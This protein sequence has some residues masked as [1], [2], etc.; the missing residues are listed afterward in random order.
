[1]GGNLPWAFLMAENSENTE[2]GDQNTPGESKTGGD[3]DCEDIYVCLPEGPGPRS[4]NKEDTSSHTT[5]QQEKLR[6]KEMDHRRLAW[7]LRCPHCLTLLLFE[8]DQ[9][10][11]PKLLV[12]RKDL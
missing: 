10:E 7:A 5:L 11:R 4:K 6:R 12:W 1:M 3:R 8:T 9:N 2:H